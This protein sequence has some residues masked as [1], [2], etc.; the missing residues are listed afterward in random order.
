MGPRR[1]RVAANAGWIPAPSTFRTVTPPA[2]GKWAGTMAN[3]LTE[4]L[5]AGPAQVRT[6]RFRESVA[7]AAQIVPV[8]RRHGPALGGRPSGPLFVTTRVVVA[9]PPALPC[10][11]VAVL[12]GLTP[13]PP[14]LIATMGGI[15]LAN[16]ISPELARTSFCSRHSRRYA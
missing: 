10:T 14:Y 1:R 2:D 7:S 3:R 13:L 12:S 6:G 16:V 11:P 15:V 9:C 4:R 8:V 5:I